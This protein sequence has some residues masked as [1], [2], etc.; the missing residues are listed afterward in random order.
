MC[1]PPEPSA[2][3]QDAVSEVSD[4]GLTWIGHVLSGSPGARLLDAH[5]DERRLEG[6]EHRW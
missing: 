2:R 4:A 3:A 6:Y 1:V 5:G